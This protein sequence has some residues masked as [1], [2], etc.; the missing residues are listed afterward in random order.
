MTLAQEWFTDSIDWQDVGEDGTKYALLEGKRDAGL[1]SYAFFIPAGFWDPPHWHSSDARVFVAKGCLKLAYSE[2]IKDGA[3]TSYPTGSFVLVPKKAVH[4][5]GADEDT[6][7]FGVA[8]GPWSTSYLDETIQ[9][10]AG[11][12]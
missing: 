2:D 12:I 7:I 11:T 5:D 1:F 8:E 9:G 6:L 4:F 10:S 3:L